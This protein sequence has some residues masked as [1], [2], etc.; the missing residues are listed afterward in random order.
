MRRTH[1]IILFL[2]ALLAFATFAFA[3]LQLVGAHR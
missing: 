2:I 3:V 1:R